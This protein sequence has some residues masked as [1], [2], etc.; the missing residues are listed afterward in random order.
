MNEVTDADWPCVHCGKP[1]YRHVQIIGLGYACP[2]SAFAYSPKTDLE[3]VKQAS[4]QAG[5]LAGR[6]AMR[7]E[8]ADCASEWREGIDPD[9]RAEIAAA[10][11]AIPLEPKL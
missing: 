6:E 4:F 5:V 1:K 2:V 7:N 8:A 3:A 10:I 9:D 11:R